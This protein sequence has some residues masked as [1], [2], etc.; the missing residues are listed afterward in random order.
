MLFKLSRKRLSVNA[1]DHL[2]QTPLYLALSKGHRKLVELLLRNGADSNAIDKNGFTPLHIVAKKQY[3]IGF[4]RMIFELSQHKPVKVNVRDRKGNTPLYYALFYRRRNL[5]QLLLKN[6]ANPNLPYANGLTPLH[7]L[8]SKYYGIGF[9]KEFFEINDVNRRK[10]NVD[11]RFKKETTSLD[12][13]WNGY[14]DFKDWMELLLT[15]G[16]NPNLCNKKGLTPLHIICKDVYESHEMVELFFKINDHNHR[17]VKVNARDTSGN[18]PLHLILQSKR[19]KIFNTVEFLLKKGANLNVA[20]NEGLTPLHIICKKNVEELYCDVNDLVELFLRMSNER[21]Q[22]LQINACDEKGRTPLQ[23]AVANLKPDVVEALLNY[24]AD[25]SNFVFPTESDFEIEEFEKKHYGINFKL[26]LASSV[27]PVIEL[28]E[29]RGYELNRRDALII[30]KL[31]LKLRSFEK[32]ADVKDCWYDD[33]KFVKEA[34]DIMINPSLSLNDLTRLRSEEAE[35][36]FT[37]RDYFKLVHSEN[38]WKLPKGPRESCTAYLCEIMSRGFIQRWT[39]DPF[40][41]LE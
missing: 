31:L 9:A 2:N 13:V 17:A 35:K 18:T 40:L 30:M 6:G 12:L 41:F 25:I 7:M 21:H 33:E 22:T 32:S 36:L 16:A 28:L 8:I 37:H 23:L 5:V 29:N 14:P 10:V 34:K 24:G 15:R 20:N 11:A 4:A 1:M 27:L 38:W 19:F 39:W 26:R 3:C